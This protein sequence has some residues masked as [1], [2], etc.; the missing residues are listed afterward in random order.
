[1]DLCQQYRTASSVKVRGV[2]IDDSQIMQV[3][4][5]GQ[6]YT[7]EVLASLEFTSARKRASVVVRDPRDGKIKVRC[8]H[9]FI[10]LVWDVLDG[11]LLIHDEFDWWMMYLMDVRC[12]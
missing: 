4:I 1:M 2:E 5:L 6:T 11:H 12:D 9:Q 8:Q 7:F 10:S 3:N